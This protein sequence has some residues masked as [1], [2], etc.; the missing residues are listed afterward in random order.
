VAS[1]FVPIVFAIALGTFAVWAFLV[2]EP[3]LGRALLNFVSVLIIA[4]PCAMGL[5]TPTAVMVGTGAAAEKGILIR[6]GESL[7]KAGKLTAVVF[8]K[9]GTL[10]RGAP[11]VT[12]VCVA[13]GAERKEVLQIA[14]SLEAASEHPL[15]EAVGR[16]GKDEG[17]APLPV[18]GFQALAGS[19]VRGIVGGKSALLGS[20]RLMADES[21]AINGLEAEAAKLA[22]LGRTTVFVAQ[23]GRAVGLMGISDQPRQSAAEAVITL[24]E[25]GIEVAMITGDNVKTAA[26]VAAAVGIDTTLAEVM[27]GD[28][29]NEIRRLQSQ[30]K[31]VAMIGD[32]INDAPALAAAD[33]GV[34]MASGTDVAIESG[35]ITLI[36]DDL[37][38]VPTAVKLSIQTMRVIKQNLFWAFLYNSLGIPVAAGALY[39]TFGVL[40]SPVIAAAAMAMSSVSV[41]S[42]SLRLGR[43]LARPL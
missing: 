38:L 1:V 7:E 40:L 26:A 9:T 25:M 6:G 3:D 37:R 39:P 27:P 24:K 2:P 28:K 32:G 22:A 35:D 5:A 31:I 14:V 18:E 23:G 34:A 29:A 36:G 16:I 30:G 21:V 4:C 10:T 20:H 8:D 19:G 43:V 42:N 15:A 13:A 41:V 33:V 11:E 12:D 17:V